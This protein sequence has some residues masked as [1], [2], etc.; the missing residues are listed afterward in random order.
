[1]K[2]I[3]ASTTRND[4]ARRA[5][6]WGAAAL[7]LAQAACS[8]GGDDQG[9]Q[10]GWKSVSSPT[11]SQLNAIW[12]TS[13]SDIWAVGDEGVAL[14]YDGDTWKKVATGTTDTLFA[15][16]GASPDDYWTG[17]DGG[18]LL[19]WN[20][21]A[22]KRDS[23]FASTYGDAI[24]SISGSGPH[25]VWITTGLEMLH[26]DGNGWSLVSAPDDI[27][28]HLDVVSSHEVW[29]TGDSRSLYR[30]VDGGPW[31]TFEVPDVGGVFIWNGISAC[32]S[33]EVWAVGAA[34]S[35]ANDAHLAYHF[36]GKTWSEAHLFEDP[37]AAASSLEAVWCR[38]PNDVWTVGDETHHFD[39]SSWQHGE[40]ENF[41]ALLTVWGSKNDLWAV[42]SLGVIY[43]NG[44]GPSQ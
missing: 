32:S 43:H 29:V 14:H 30:R 25:D 36:D 5:S 9:E 40:F 33:A 23:S 19:H 24:M 2:P 7:V 38:S 34:I 22:W 44:S 15:V 39:G 42:G 8:S 26:T 3:H 18:E 20:G 35:A 28:E 27:V 31:E 41:D 11:E 6:R 17:T 13:A 4:L 21:S 37:E 16:W 1:M 12:G 10:L